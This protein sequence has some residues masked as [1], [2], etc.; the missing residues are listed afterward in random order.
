MNYKIRAL[1]FFSKQW[2]KLDK[3][4]KKIINKKIE[5]IKENPF[6]YKRLKSDTPVFRVRLSIKSKET[7]LIYAVVKPDIIIICLL[8]RKKYYADLNKYLK[9]IIS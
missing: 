2:K 9:H 7:R 1:D 6:R 4:S 3:K 8:D 5:L